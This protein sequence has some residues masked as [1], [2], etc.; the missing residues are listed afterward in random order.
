MNRI[1]YVKSEAALKSSGVFTGSTLPM[2]LTMRKLTYGARLRLIQIPPDQEPFQGSVWA[3]YEHE[4]F[5]GEVLDVWVHTM[6][7][8]REDDDE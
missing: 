2:C 6:T 1:Y 8:Y 5:P 4:D 7:A 3:E